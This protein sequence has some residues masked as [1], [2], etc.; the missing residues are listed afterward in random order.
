MKTETTVISI[1]PAAFPPISMS[2]NTIG[3]VF[4]ISLRINVNTNIN[5]NNAK[6]QTKHQIFQTTKRSGELRGEPEL[7][8]TTS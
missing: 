3:S 4:A 6:F 7:S 5:K 1:R 2:K 8:Y